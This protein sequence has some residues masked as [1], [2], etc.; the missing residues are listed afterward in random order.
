MIFDTHIE[1][2]IEAHGDAEVDYLAQIDRNTHLFTFNPRM[3]S[4]HLQGRL[5]SMFSKMISPN[6]ILEL[7]TFTGYSALC[8]A[9]G[10][11]K[12]GRLH[13]VES[14]DEMEDLI[15]GNLALSPFNHQIELHICEALDYCKQTEETFDLVFID[16]DK[17][18]YSDYYHALFDKIRPGGY[19]IADNTLWDGKVLET[20]HPNDKQTIAIK[21]F[22]DMIAQDQR[23]EKIILPLRD[24]MTIIR[25]K[26]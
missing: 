11:T 21:E 24:G 2:Y 17:R 5:L 1:D 23:I 10:L 15:R 14:N 13:T 3:L 26:D 12:N 18:E 7:G 6:R 4:G 20:P 16:A 25:K 8:L 19:I 22:N 9:E